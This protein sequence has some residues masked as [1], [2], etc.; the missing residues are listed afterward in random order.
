MR[1]NHTHIKII[2]FEL[3]SRNIELKLYRTIMRPI[4]IYGSDVNSDHGGKNALRI[5]E[6]EVARKISGAVK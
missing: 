5:F 4:L 2:R 3:L 1:T 6:R